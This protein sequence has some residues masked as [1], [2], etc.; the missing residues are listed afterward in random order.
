VS[1]ISVVSVEQH[2]DS[3]TEA[4]MENVPEDHQVSLY[5]KFR[6]GLVGELIPEH[7]SC[8]A[9]TRLP[10]MD[11]EGREFAEDFALEVVGSNAPPAPTL[12]GPLDGA[13]TCDSIPSFAWEPGSQ[14]TA[15]QIQV[16]DDDDFASAVIDTEVSAT[17]FAPATPLPVGRYYWRVRSAYDCGHGSW[18]PAWSFKQLDCIH[19]P[20][21]MREN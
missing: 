16:N 2:L 4:R 7:P 3:L 6:S 13:G 15:S 19:L 5:V 9:E 1:G 21:A 11:Y 8:E 10:R 17:S 18:S 14:A 20:V 12:T